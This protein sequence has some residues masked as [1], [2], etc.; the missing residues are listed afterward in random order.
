MMGTVALA[1][2]AVA[3]A[4]IAKKLIAER[5]ETPHL[6]GKQLNLDWYVRNVLP[7]AT[8][9]GKAIQAGDETPLDPRLFS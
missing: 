7:H 9:I 3:Q 8:A 4:R 2:E 1:V 6:V 5:G